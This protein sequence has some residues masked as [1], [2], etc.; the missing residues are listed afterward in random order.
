MVKLHHLNRSRSKRIIWLLEALGIDYEI[1]AYQRDANTNLAPPELLAIHPL[2]KS[3]VIEDK[4]LV[5][6]ESGAIVEYL[7]EQYDDT[8]RLAPKVATPEYVAYKQWLHFAEGSAVLPMLLAYFVKMD[9][10][11]TNF[12]EAYAGGEVTRILNYMNGVLADSDYLLG[13]TFSAA[14]ILNSFVIDRVNA[15]YGLEAY[16]NL[17]DYLARISTMPACIKAEQLE[18]Q[19]DIS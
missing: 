15:S 2:G 9:G 18:A 6:A 14:D 1:I 17:K 4:G 16:P 5:I 3:P 19:Y 10:A 12:L 7:V 8:G 13:E 11:K